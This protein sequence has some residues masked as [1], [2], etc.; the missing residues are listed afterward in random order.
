MPL[1]PLSSQ[2]YSDIA[3][4]PY[5]TVA[6][7]R[8]SFAPVAGGWRAIVSELRHPTA[9]ARYHV[10]VVDRTGKTRFTSETA[11]LKDAVRSAERGVL[12]RN[13]LRLV[14]RV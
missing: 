4:R 2:G 1:P 11:S 10:A 9:Q 3:D 13:A 8:A 14:P 6:R 5:W 12:A 7:G